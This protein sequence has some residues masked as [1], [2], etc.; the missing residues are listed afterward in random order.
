MNNFYK[1]LA[2]DSG[3]FQDF[4]KSMN[5]LVDSNVSEA[6]IL[7]KGNVYLSRLV[8]DD[9]WLPDDCAQS[10]ADKYAQH[11]LYIDPS[12]RYCVVSFVWRPGQKTPIHDHTVWGLVGVMRGAE[13]CDEYHLIENSPTAQ[14]KS[15]ILNRGQI[16]SVSPTIGDW[17][18][19][20]NHEENHTSISIH[21]YGGDIGS[22]NR[23]MINANG[24]IVDFV[25]GYSTS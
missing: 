19:V 13:L 5:E 11:L 24:E 22:I 21:V 3:S 6:E 18:Q 25:S 17:H 20:S 9:S 10:Y 7:L 4:I 8:S 12:N 1:I 14:G 15:H 23:H 16:D 2:K